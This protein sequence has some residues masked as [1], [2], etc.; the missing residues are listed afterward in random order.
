MNMNINTIPPKSG[1]SFKI[2]KGMFLKVIC[3][4][5][6]QVSDMVAFNAD[7]IS[8][9]MFNGK[10]F[11]YEENIYLTK[12]NF[13]YSNESNKMFEIIEDTCGKHDYLL[14]P[15]CSRTMEHFYQDFSDGPSCRK[16]LYENLKQNGIAID[17][18]PTAFN[19]FMNV[20]WQKMEL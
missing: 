10:T 14:A 1:A 9:Y 8:E 15:C 13:L 12:G 17:N 11:D 16:N 3:S 19:I 2:R 5:G 20:P 6:E 4:E 7:N 18:I